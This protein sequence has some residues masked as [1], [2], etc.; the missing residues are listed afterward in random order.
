MKRLLWLI[1]LMII[2]V[3]AFAQGEPVHDIYGSVDV[4]NVTLTR[5]EDN[6]LSLTI[7]GTPATCSPVVVEQ[8]QHPYITH[9]DLNTGILIDVDLFTDPPQEGEVCQTLVAFSH[10][11]ELEGEFATDESYLLTINNFTAW[12]YLVRPGQVVMDLE[13]Q[14]VDIGDT[15]LMGWI[16]SVPTINSVTWG[17]SA[18]RLVININGS[19]PDGCQGMLVS[20]ITP[21][22][23]HPDFE[24]VH[25]FR[26]LSI[27]ASCMA[28][29]A[30]FDGTIETDIPQ[31]AEVTI[32]VL[33]SLYQTQP[34][35]RIVEPIPVSER[36]IQVESVNIS[37]AEG[38]YQVQVIGT[39]NGDCGIPLQEISATRGAVS[40]IEIFDIVA[41][42]APCTRN[43]IFYDNI[44]TVS[45]MPVVVNGT[46]YFAEDAEG[47]VPEGDLMQ[48]DTVIENVEVLV[49]ESFPMQLQLNVSGYHPDGCNYPVQIDQSRDGSTVTVHIYREV[50]A[51]VM[52]TMN[53]V[54]YEE[55]IQIEGNFEGGT[56]TIHVNDQ[57][58]TVEL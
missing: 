17:A 52:C 57:T 33:G 54:G 34:H 51:D 29:P 56:I 48:V 58:V 7:Y 16:N 13:A 8:E 32:D 45:E 30:E 49:Q 26:V 31:T 5:T 12:V 3:P 55:T 25:L 42:A 40:A 46:V 20:Y 39:Q 53:I 44:F 36:P 47:S 14:Q 11:V 21:G 43:L 41:E 1:T 4:T 35:D 28:S 9:P 15:E 38:D 50:P 22:W 24:V 18:E 6:Q 27:A 2:A 23:L 37:G 19:L 10:I